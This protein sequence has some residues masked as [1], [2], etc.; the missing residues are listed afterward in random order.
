MLGPDVLGAEA[1]P[2]IAFRS[3]SVRKTAEGS[4]VATGPLALHGQT[5]DVDVTVTRAGEV[6]RGAATVR[7]RD[8]GIQPVSIAGGAVQVK[9]EVRIEFEVRLAKTAARSGVPAPVPALR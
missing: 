6:Y 7:Q 1:F 2:T 3:R 5:R 4:W 9:N 8:F